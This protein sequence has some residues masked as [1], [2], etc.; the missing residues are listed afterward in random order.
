[1][2]AI[3]FRKKSPCEIR[4]DTK[5]KEEYQEEKDKQSRKGQYHKKRKITVTYFWSN[6]IQ[7]D[8]D[9]VNEKQ[10]IGR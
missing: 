8:I 7:C 1:M 2:P 3:D 10:W 6:E 4:R 5:G 9:E